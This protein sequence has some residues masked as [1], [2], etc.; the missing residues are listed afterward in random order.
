MKVLVVLA[1]GFEEVEALAPIDVLRRAGASVTVASLFDRDDKVASGSHGVKV[2]CETVFS[3]AVKEEFDAVV[4][5]GG[6]KGAQNLSASSEVSSYLKKMNEKKAFVCAICASPAL[7]LYPLGLLDGK[8]AVCYPGMEIKGKAANFLEQRVCRD[9]NII[10]GRGAG[11]AME[12]SLEIVKALFGKDGETL[13][14][15]LHDK[16]VC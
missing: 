4:L 11:C 6:L 15:S 1:D 14:C 13:A 7:V 16:M 2:V 5:P 10:T 9:D 12:F 8:N 3:E